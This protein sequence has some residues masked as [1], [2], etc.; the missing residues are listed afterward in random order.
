MSRSLPFDAFHA[1]VL[2]GHFA[3][4]LDFVAPPTRNTLAGL[5]VYEGLPL[6]E[7]FPAP[8]ALPSVRVRRRWSTP[9]VS[10]EDLVFSSSHVPLEPEFAQRYE[11]EARENHT[12]YARRI[13]PWGSAGRPRLLYLHGYLQPETAF[14]EAGF[15]VPMALYLGVEV[16]QIQPPYHGRRAP[17]SS[18]YSGQLYWTADVVRSVESLRQSIADV[19][20]LLG[21]LLAEDGCPVG[22]GGLSLGGAL[23]L[24]LTCVEPRLAFAAP[25]IAHLDLGAV[26]TDVPVLGAMRRGLAS[27]GWRPEDLANFYDRL[28][29]RELRPAIPRDRILL[30]AA[31]D[32]RFFAPALVEELWQRWDQ[33]TIRW[34][35]GSHMGFMLHIPE[36]VSLLRDLMER[37]EGDPPRRLHR[38]VSGE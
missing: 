5:E 8:R 26:M 3:G 31:R 15:L 18:W 35:P 25:W 7:L 32:D 34:F 21:W 37:V 38:V 16:V 12:V 9:V 13:R 36:A 27:F 2:A 24:L 11:S 4:L 29:L 30:L 22:V 10:G 33:P 1:D 14:E 28:G 17:R 6:R 20:A 23:S 19:R